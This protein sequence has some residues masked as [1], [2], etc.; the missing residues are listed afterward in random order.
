[1]DTAKVLADALTAGDQVALSTVLD[2]EVVLLS[3]ATDRLRFTGREA[4]MVLL[5][6]VIE[7]YEDM[8][9]STITTAGQSST[10]V[11]SAWI[12]HHPF[13]E[14]LLLR[15]GQ[16]GRVVGIQAS[17]RPLSGL[18]A[19]TAEVGRRL[20][21]RR[22]RL[23]EMLFLVLSAQLRIMVAVGDRVGAWLASSGLLPS[24]R[25]GRR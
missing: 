1:M 5:T 6:A 9:A 8:Q 18:V 25:V 4:V 14:T 10:V 15:L 12:G 7:A 2:E 11:I 23:A 24:R 17:I 16:D 3:P 19:V 20:A 13:Q 21:R 22:G